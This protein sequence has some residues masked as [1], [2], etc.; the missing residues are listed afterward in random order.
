MGKVKVGDKVRVVGNSCF[1]GFEVGSIVTV[2]D[3]YNGGIIK[4][5]DGIA[6]QYIQIDE[7]E[8]IAPALI[9]LGGEYTSHNGHKWKCIF[10]D[11][12]K[13]WLAPEDLKSSAFVFKTDGSNISQ[14]GKQWD[15]KFEPAV[16]TVKFRG[17]VRLG[18]LDPRTV[19]PDDPNSD[20][21]FNMTVD[22]IDGTPDWSTAKVT[23]A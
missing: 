7:Y 16:E 2:L 20:H 19:H 17:G 14:G 4:V 21:K 3:T 5:T 10:V 9:V 15:I 1:H 18:Y 13:A 22:F 6:E 11:G 8:P 12:D 23:G